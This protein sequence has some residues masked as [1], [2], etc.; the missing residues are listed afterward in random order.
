LGG[1]LGKKIGGVLIKGWRGK[2]VQHGGLNK[3]GIRLEKMLGILRGAK[4]MKKS[5]KG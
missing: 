2:I 4:I 5:R 3:S 1:E